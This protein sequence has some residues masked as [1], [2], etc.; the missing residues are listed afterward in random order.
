MFEHTVSNLLCKKE[1]PQYNES[2]GHVS[3][4]YLLVLIVFRKNKRKCFCSH[5]AS[6]RTVNLRKRGV[7]VIV[8]SVD[9]RGQGDS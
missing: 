3:L 2:A 9:D 1:L 7:G 6:W 5:L 4:R 8:G